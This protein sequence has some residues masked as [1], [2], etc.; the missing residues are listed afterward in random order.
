MV[1]FS[2]DVDNVRYDART[3]RMIAGYGNGALA[4]LD[5]EAADHTFLGMPKQSARQVVI[6]PPSVLASVLAG[7][8]E[9]FRTRLD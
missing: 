8:H 7:S 4:F 2:A 5:R 1:K 9:P 3:H 6:A